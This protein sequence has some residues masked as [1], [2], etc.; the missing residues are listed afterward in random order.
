MEVSQKL[1]MEIAFWLPNLLYRA[2][3]C[4]DDLAKIE[5]RTIQ[6]SSALGAIITGTI[7]PCGPTQRH[8]G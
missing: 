4:Q 2:V 7:S 3:I 6:I 1:T 5:V 8:L